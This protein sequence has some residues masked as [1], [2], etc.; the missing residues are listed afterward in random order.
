M[1]PDGQTDRQGQPDSVVDI[2]ARGGA[3]Q[4]AAAPPLVAGDEPPDGEHGRIGYGRR[5]RYTP[6]ALAVG[7]VAALFLIGLAERRGRGEP[8]PVA[9]GGAR[10]VS[11]L[12]GRPAP[13]VSLALLDGGRLRLADLRGRVVVVNFWGWWCVPCRDEA[14]ALEALARAAPVDP[15]P[16]AV[17]GVSVRLR[18]DE[19][20][21]RAFVRE[22]GLTY[23]VGR[24][25]GGV[26][27]LRGPI[28]AAF[29]V[30]PF[31]PTTVVIAPD[32]TVVAV[33]IGPLDE[34]RLRELVA[35]AA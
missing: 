4:H 19:A 20:A 32:G 28:E 33:H 2:P 17:V 31:Y 18:D 24:D 23:P 35:G 5:G 6:L 7:L 3:G 9:E 12:V 8:A 22:L 30:D 13:D 1:D 21:A 26:D 11:Q 29:G 15:A 27:P 16:V 10:R 25:L 34:E 14:P